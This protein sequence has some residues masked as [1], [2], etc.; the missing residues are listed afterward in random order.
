MSIK[1]EGENFCMKIVLFTKIFKGCSVAEV[2]QAAAGLGFGGLDLAVRTGQCVTPANVWE[3]LPRA[4]RLWEEMGLSVPLVTGETHHTDPKDKE[5]EG[6]YAACAAAGIPYIK[7]PY[8]N[9]KAGDDFRRGL[10]DVRRA[11]EGFYELSE[12]YN[13]CSVMHTHSGDHYGANALGAMQLLG[14]FAPRFLGVYLDP[15]HL[16]ADGESTPMAISI[17]GEYLKMVGVKNIRYTQKENGRWEKEWWPLREGLVHWPDVISALQ[18]V[19]YD[20]PLS[21]HTEYAAPPG[22]PTARLNK[23]E[24]LEVAARD[25]VY[26][27]ESI[28]AGTGVLP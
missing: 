7:L 24:A 21:F 6:L 2:G 28:F 23:D 5:V 18:A 19:G 14:D 1:I 12:T 10:D 9:W 20:G 17:A 27:K 25:L 22:H 15:A 26:L 16:A 11:L 3:E 13:V 4:T 8:W